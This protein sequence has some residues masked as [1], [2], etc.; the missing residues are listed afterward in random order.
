M[1][2]KW[3]PATRDGKLFRLIEECA[4]VQHICCKIGRFGLV[5]EENV[6]YSNKLESLQS[7]LLDLD[8]A[9]REIIKEFNI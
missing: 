8:H 5:Y 3:L 7:E 6:H 1:D 9:I 2:E 4:E